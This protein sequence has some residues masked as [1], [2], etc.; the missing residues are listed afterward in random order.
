MGFDKLL[1]AN[2]HTTPSACLSD[3]TPIK[4]TPPNVQQ[5]EKLSMFVAPSTLALTT[6]RCV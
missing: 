2:K 6:T 3:A 4:N 1:V 5:S